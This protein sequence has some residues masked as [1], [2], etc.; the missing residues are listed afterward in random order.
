MNRYPGWLNLLVVGIVLVAC[1]FALPSFFGESRAIQVTM[2]D[3][4]TLPADL[5]DVVGN[6]LA[7][8]GLPTGEIFVHRNRL[9]V[10]AAS[11][12]EQEAIKLLLQE[13]IAPDEDS[14][15]KVATNFAPLMPTWLRTLG[16]KPV[17]LGLDL[18]GGVHLLF[19]VDMPRAIAQYQDQM[20]SAIKQLAK[21]EKIRGVRSRA[22]NQTIIVTSR[23]TQRCDQLRTVIE[24]M[25]E[26]FLIAEGPSDGGCPELRLTMSEP[27]IQARQAFAIEQNTTT[28]RSRL[29]Q[30]GVA[31]PL[32]QQQGA[33]RIVVQLPGVGDPAEVIQ[34]LSAVA[35]LEFRGECKTGSPA[36]AAQSGRAP[37]GC[38]LYPETAAGILSPAVLERDVIATGGELVDARASRDAQDGPIVNVTLDGSASKRMLEHTKTNVGNR[39]AVVFIETLA[40]K[41]PGQEK[42]VLETSERVI[43]LATIQ[44]VFSDRFRISGF[45][46]AE[47]TEL[48]VLLRAGALAAPIY[49]VEQRTVGPTLG[50]DNIEKGKMAVIIGFLLVVVF[51]LV[52]YRLFG[53][54][55]NM[56]LFANLIIMM[57]VLSLLQASLTLPGI[58]GIVLTVGMAVDANVLI[59][60]RIREELRNGNSPQAAIHAGYDKAFSSIAD[61]NITTLIAAL[62]LWMFGTGP[63]QGFATTLAIG[64]M[65]SM[66]T[67]IIGTRALVNWIYG[68]KKVEKLSI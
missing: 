54:F 42:P 45:T 66:F 28:L 27:Q 67:A 26:G 9:F 29:D 34:T 30:L 61:A 48:A 58:A 50:K 36:A 2:E 32:V 12:D 35:T 51:M 20:A 53:L 56:A 43:S 65:S 4:A 31:E 19:E 22:G 25:E 1:F 49:V 59:F 6:L 16:G 41:V 15:Y 47:A 3:N 63:I 37:V 33:N 64:I 62:V 18:R 46:S 8:A 17:H 55:A 40:R 21:N 5:P 52:Y 7:E 44:G 14:G 68:D 24:D 38:L 39:M 57:A 10:T 13:K 60:E 11:D 23:D